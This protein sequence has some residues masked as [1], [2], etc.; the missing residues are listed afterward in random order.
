MAQLS[1]KRQRTVVDM[2]EVIMRDRENGEHV[3]VINRNESDKTVTLMVRRPW[4]GTWDYSGGKA[5]LDNAEAGVIS[6]ILTG[7]DMTYRLDTLK[8]IDYTSY[9]A[10]NVNAAAVER[11]VEARCSQLDIERA[12][13]ANLREEKEVLLLRLKVQQAESGDNPFAEDSYESMPSVDADD[14]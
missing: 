10:E 9:S 5:T 2:I 14:L 6:S 13:A 4:E 3:L 11:E 8:A 1:G 12:K 7:G